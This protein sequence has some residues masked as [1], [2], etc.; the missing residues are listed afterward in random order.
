MN[1]E[2]V[3]AVAAF[4]FATSITPGPNNTMLLASGANFGLKKTMPH[5]FG[6][7]IG[8]PV[9]LIGVG[10]GLGQLFSTFPITYR[11][12]QVV[13]AF[14]LLYLAWLIAT[15]SPPTDEGEGVAKP[16]GL[17]PICEVVLRVVLR[18]L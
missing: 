4:S 1:L 13:S 7:N 10:L 6:I 5:I 12:L 11:V 15:S 14:Y 16:I 8:F 9:M 18:R 2:T 17:P 3:A